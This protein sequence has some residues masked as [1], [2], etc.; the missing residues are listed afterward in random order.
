[1]RRSETGTLD[2]A[3]RAG[4]DEAPAHPRYVALPN[5]SGEHAVDADIDVL[6]G[7]VGEHLC[8]DF[9]ISEPRVMRT[10]VE[11]ILFPHA[12]L[13]SFAVRPLPA[14]AFGQGRRGGK[15]NTWRKVAT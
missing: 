14:R 7:R 12:D 5:V 13:P 1:M 10:T 4:R 2:S 15:L 6:Q 8:R 3:Q 11:L 9:D